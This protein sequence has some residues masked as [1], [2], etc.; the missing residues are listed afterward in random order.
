MT[1]LPSRAGAVLW[2]SLCGGRAWA[3]RER[4]ADLLAQGADVPPTPIVAARTTAAVATAT[5]SAAKAGSPA[6]ERVAIDDG[7]RLVS[8][9]GFDTPTVLRELRFCGT[10]ASAPAE[11]D[12]TTADPRVPEAEATFRCIAYANSSTTV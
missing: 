9:A 12:T 3:S 8:E 2:N 10:V 1:P 6:F 5:A 4:A 11:A 7:V